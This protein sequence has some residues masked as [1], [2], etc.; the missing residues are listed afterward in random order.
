MKKIN[1][2]IAVVM[3]ITILSAC[4]TS[5]ADNESKGTTTVIE[6]TIKKVTS[7]ATTKITEAEDVKKDMK[8]AVLTCEV[9]VIED[10]DKKIIVDYIINVDDN[11]AQH[12]FTDNPL[13]NKLWYDMYTG[14]GEE[15]YEFIDFNFDGYMDI[16]TQ[17]YGAYVN[18]Y[19]NIR[20]WNDETNEFE[21]N[22][23][24]MEISNPLVN[25]DKQQIFSV[26][27]DRGFGNYTLYSIVDG[28][29]EVIAEILFN[30]KNDGSYSYTQSI[31][32]SEA[33]L[34]NNV[35]ELDDIWEGYTIE[36][37]Q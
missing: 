5:D 34:I 13:F 32:N 25:S 18:Q 27:Y 10:N 21:L 35:S 2:I 19:Y 22:S 16:K 6:S 29:L 7:I 8:N 9:N 36:I 37:I 28:E 33:K 23:D 11:Y 30:M 12:E 14:Q 1:L 24:F 4:T 26:N 31:N 3:V 20:I 15:L 17:M